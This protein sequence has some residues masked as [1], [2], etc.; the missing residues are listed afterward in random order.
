MTESTW[1]KSDGH[2]IEDYLSLFLELITPSWI[3]DLG[4]VEPFFTN[5]L[6]LHLLFERGLIP[7]QLTILTYVSMTI[8]WS[9]VTARGRRRKRLFTSPSSLLCRKVS[10]DTA[11]PFGAFSRHVANSCCSKRWESKV[12]T[13]FFK[14]QTWRFKSS[15]DTSS[16]VNSEVCISIYVLIDCSLFLLLLLLSLLFGDGKNKPI[17]FWFQCGMHLF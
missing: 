5:S 14:G 11:N 2:S 9:L 4:A 1:L 6:S 13:S 7:E 16:A 10:V 12:S 17:D 3:V 8:V 15:S